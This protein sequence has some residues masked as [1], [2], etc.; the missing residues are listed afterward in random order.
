MAET[1]AETT[2]VL[3][4]LDK[5]TARVTTLLAP[6]G[7]PVHWGSLEIVAQACEKRPPE[8]PPE[9]SAFLEI[10]ER[11]P[12]ALPLRLFTGWMLASSPA[13]NPLE[14]PVYDVWVIDCKTD[15]PERSRPTP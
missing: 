15:A 13:L 9:T 7:R 2:A 10:S 12:D 3:G 4:G 6:L 11:R 14:H 1:G 5:V 8:E